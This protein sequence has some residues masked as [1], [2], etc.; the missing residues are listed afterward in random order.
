MP[1][2][3]PDDIQSVSHDVTPLSL[4]NYKT[5]QTVYRHKSDGRF[6]MDTTMQ[7]SASCPPISPVRRKLIFA[8]W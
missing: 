3:P 7:S 5:V 4:T 6:E 1:E 8:K 2:D